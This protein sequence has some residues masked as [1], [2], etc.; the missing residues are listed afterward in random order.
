[1]TT[2]A[3]P[4]SLESAVEQRALTQVCR[5]LLDPFRKCRFQEGWTEE[6]RGLAQVWQ[7][8]GLAQ[9]WQELGELES[10]ES[11]LAQAHFLV[12]SRHDCSGLHLHVSRFQGSDR[13]GTHQDVSQRNRTPRSRR[14]SSTC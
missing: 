12:R 14:C 3:R 11:E 9:V 7:E 6:E 13:N 5:A 1:M 4:C 10:G 2:I 8:P